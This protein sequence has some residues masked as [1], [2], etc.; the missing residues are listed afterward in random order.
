MVEKWTRFGDISALFVI[1]FLVP[2]IFLV[3]NGYN[4][5]HV[6]ISF[7]ILTTF[8]VLSALKFVYPFF[9]TW[10]GTLLSIALAWGIGVTSVI[11]D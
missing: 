9:P 7:L 11:V 4:K 10:G 1:A 2:P 8:L 6:V 3:E 5:R